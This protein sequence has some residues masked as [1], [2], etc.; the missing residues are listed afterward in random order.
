GFLF[1]SLGVGAAAILG[2][3]G[4]LSIDSRSKFA[5]LLAGAG[6]FLVLSIVALAR[7][8][9]DWV[10]AGFMASFSFAYVA[11]AL[12]FKGVFSWVVILAPVL[13]VALVYAALMY[14]RDARTV[15]ASWA[16]FLG[17]CRCLVY[18]ILAFVFLL[19]GCQTW[20]TT[21]SHSKVILLFDV[22][23]S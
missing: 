14:V 6:V 2:V 16:A 3:C 21:E 20:D 23:D 22:S 17:F 11:V 10:P 4:I 15:H 8:M 5:L 19:P 9:R 13:A 1:A 12:L 18:G 7:Q